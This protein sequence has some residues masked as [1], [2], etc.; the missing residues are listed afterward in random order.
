M[1]ITIQDNIKALVLSLKKLWFWRE[2][3]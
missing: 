3:D 2:S 1:R